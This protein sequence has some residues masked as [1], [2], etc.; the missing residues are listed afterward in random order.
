MRHL[1][2]FGLKYSSLFAASCAAI[3]VLS[4]NAPAFAADPDIP[5]IEADAQRGSIKEEI[6]LAA[7]YFIGRGV[8]QDVKASA[9]WYEKAANSGDPTAQN[10]IGYLYQVGIGVPKDPERAARWYQRSAA[11]G[12]VLAKFNLGVAYITGMGVKADTPMG[13]QLLR[14]AAAQGNGYA[15]CYLGDFYHAGVYVPKNPAESQQWYARGAALHNPLAEYRLGYLLSEAESKEQD[16]KKAA[17]LFR[18]S[19]SAGYIPAQHQLALLVIHHPALAK[20]PEEARS[21]LEAAA[22][23]GEWRSS[24]V[25]GVLSRDGIGAPSDPRAAYYHFEVAQLQGG[26]A[27]GQLLV[28]DL[29]ALSNK[30]SPAEI[31]A[32][33]SE[34]TAWANQHREHLQFVYKNDVAGSNFPAYA[35]EFPEHSV[36]AGRLVP[37]SPI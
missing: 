36:Y 11:G 35:L 32:V 1:G 25:L 20:G 16:F 4:V 26:N 13:I 9:Y 22:A 18:Q 7:A 23:A 37:V 31:A 8:P 29:K 3:F 12:L 6:Q 17:S 28:N 2:N 27:A 33:D 24:I 34:A 19:A 15:A 30:L 5:R 10:E 21:L 14:E